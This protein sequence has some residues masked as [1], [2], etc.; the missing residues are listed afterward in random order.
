M[1]GGALTNFIRNVFVRNFYLK[2]IAAILTLSLYIWV[3]ED[4][5]T[6]EPGYAPLEVSAPDGMVLVSDP[7]GWVEFTLR[8]RR[9]LLN[10][11]DIDDL[12]PIRLDL[13]PAD[14]DSYVR[15]TSAMVGVPP[16]IRVTDIEPPAVYIELEPEDIKTVDVEPQIAGEPANWYTVEEIRTSPQTITLRGPQSLLAQMDSVPTEEIDITG[17]SSSLRRSVQPIIDH[18][19]ITAELDD[20]IVVEVDI[21][22]EEVTKTIDDI[23]V[24][25]VN[26]S[27]DTV[28]DPDTARLT[29]TG[30]LP[31]LEDMDQD[32]LRLEIDLT[33]ED[34]RPPGT[35]SRPAEAVNLP[36]R[37]QVDAIFPERFRVTTEAPPEPEPEL[38]EEEPTDDAE[39]TL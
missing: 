20:D 38:D 12:D 1:N 6:S 33:E 24:D 8:G 10:R 16:N 18:K 15:I 3:A 19:L 9:S 32:L 5:E 35:Y 13:D 21:E 22:T 23:S 11:L 17:R 36:D 14:D 26:T 7:E 28:V 30:P 37:V 31:I 2:F 25:A 29:V 34:Q 4:R 39:E 27:Y